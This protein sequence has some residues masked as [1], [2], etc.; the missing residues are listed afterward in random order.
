M[1]NGQHVRMIGEG[2]KVWN[3][4]KEQHPAVIP[5]LADADL[6]AADLRGINLVGADLSHADLSGALLTGA[7]LVKANLLGAN[8]TNAN[9]ASARL[10]GADLTVSTLSGANLSHAR[11]IAASL[12]SADLRSA[13]LVDANLSESSLREAKL[14]HARL[15]LTDL[16]HADFSRADLHHASLEGADLSVSN[17]SGANLTSADLTNVQLDGANLTSAQLDETNFTEAQV[18]ETIFGDNDLSTVRGLETMRHWAPSTIGIDTLF[19]SDGRISEAFLR[20]AGVPDDFLTFVPSFVGAAIQFYSCFISYSHEDEDFAQRLH[21][22]MRSEKL[23]VWYASEDMK[24]GKKLHEQIFQA[25]QIH[26]KLLLVLSK[27]S[28]QSEWVMTEIRRARK[29]EREENRRKLFP[30]RLVNMDAIGQ[31]ECFDADTGKDLAIEIREY[32]IPDFSLW[33]EHDAFEAEFA[34]LLRD[35]RASLE[36]F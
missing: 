18:G 4:W 36:P 13:N 22:R 9:L 10:D 35:L 25:I 29:V 19:K 32:Y 1:A 31:W 16:N 21:S 12:D 33:K 8:L 2:A 24:G 15:D 26:D 14:I 34:K 11:I 7:Y 6:R 3:E 5:D 23:R 30:I 27:D 28:M 20:E 17:F